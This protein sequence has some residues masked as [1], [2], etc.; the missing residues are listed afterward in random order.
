M[1]TGLRTAP[2]SKE[3]TVGANRGRGEKGAGNISRSQRTAATIR[4]ILACQKEHLEVGS[5]GGITYLLREAIVDTGGQPRRKGTVPRQL[6]ALGQ[7]RG[8]W[9]WR[10][11]KGH[12]RGGGGNWGDNNT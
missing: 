12:E 10:S 11:T 8:W 3:L 7:E 6:K 2:F 1:A 9:W 5:E 4:V